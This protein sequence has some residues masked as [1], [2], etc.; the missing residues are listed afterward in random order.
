MEKYPRKNKIF[1]KKI[2][3]HLHE[4]EL[5]VNTNQ[6]E[7]EISARVPIPS[8]RANVEENLKRYG[9]I[10]N[11]LA[12]KSKVSDLNLEGISSLNIS[13]TVHHLGEDGSPNLSSLSYRCDESPDLSLSFSIIGED[14]HRKMIS[15]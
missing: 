4:Q 12:S 1:E 3:H 8:E 2:N 7:S 10:K 15:N 6:S 11:N 14:T 13:K 5:E 9:D